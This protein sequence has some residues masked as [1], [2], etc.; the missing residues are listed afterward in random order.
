MGKQLSESQLR[1]AGEDRMT[2]TVVPVQRQEKQ[3]WRKGGL[4]VFLR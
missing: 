1:E 4:K 3:D 2:P